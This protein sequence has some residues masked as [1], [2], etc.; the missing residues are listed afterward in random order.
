MPARLMQ[1]LELKCNGAILQ[2]WNNIE[3]AL[4]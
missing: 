1:L 3:I 4:S 2:A